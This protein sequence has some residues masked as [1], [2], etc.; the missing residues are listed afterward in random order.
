MYKFAIN[1]PFFFQVVES[2]KDYA[3]ITTDLNG[4]ISSWNQGAEALLQYQENEII[5]N[6]A[7][8]FYTDEDRV[9]NVPSQEMTKASLNGSATD[10]RCHKRKDGSEF[11]CNG[12]MY[13][14]LDAENHQVGFTKIMRDLTEIRKAEVVQK[15]ANDYLSAIISTGREP[16]VVLTKELVVQS[17]NEAFYRTFRV[18]KEETEGMLT[19]NLGNG[20]WNIPELRGL[21]NDIL[22]VNTTVEN[23][24][25][26]HHFEHIGTRDMLLNANRF[27]SYLQDYELI[28]LAIEDVT[29]KNEFE[30]QKDEFIALASHEL[31]SPLTGIRA[32]SDFVAREME[33]MVDSP[34]YKPVAKMNKLVHRLNRMVDYLLDISKIQSAGLSLQKSPV[35][36]NGLIK[37]HIDDLQEHSEKKH[38]VS[39]AAETTYIVPFDAFTIGQVIRNLLSNAMKYS[40]A[41][42]SIEINISQNEFVTTVSMTDHGIGIPASEQPKIFKRFS[43]ASNAKE[44]GFPGI[45]LGLYLTKEIIKAHKGEIGLVSKEN[46]GTYFWFT[47]PLK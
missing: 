34:L 33:G 30:M 37:E 12:M 17:A 43:R 13:P 47:L 19:Y 5:G 24:E 31:K 32:Y 27:T 36:L 6:N 42:T 3:I 28:L 29:L 14:L 40:P 1:E 16:F 35:N 7:A 4:I 25:V 26:T 18:S 2:L 38:N 22:P 44:K 8:I 11:W 15:A 21:L 10:I 39:L 41:N 46:E 20:Q 9:K 23:Y 45:G